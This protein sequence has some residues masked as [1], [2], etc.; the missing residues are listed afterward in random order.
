[1]LWCVPACPPTVSVQSRCLFTL[2]FPSP[3]PLLS[4]INTN[5]KHPPGRNAKK[6]QRKHLSGHLLPYLQC[7]PRC[8]GSDPQNLKWHHLYNSFTSHRAAVSWSRFNPG[9]GSH[10]GFTFNPGRSSHP[11]SRSIPVGVHT[12]GSRSI[13]VRAHK[14]PPIYRWL[15][16]TLMV[17]SIP[18]SQHVLG[19]MKK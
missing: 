7:H 4:W 1:M 5:G 18:L 16:L 3:L 10:P 11:G 15:S 13:P 8:D 19:R 17:L 12:R 14:R 6:R 2:M 9:R